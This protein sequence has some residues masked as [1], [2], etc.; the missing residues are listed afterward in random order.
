MAILTNGAAP[1]PTP[2]KPLRVTRERLWFLYCVAELAA[3]EIQDVTG[4]GVQ[5]TLNAIARWELSHYARAYANLQV[6]PALQRMAW[7]ELG[8]ADDRHAQKARKTVDAVVAFVRA[9]RDEAKMWSE[10][11]RITRLIAPRDWEKVQL[12]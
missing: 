7:R 12:Q 2:P 10:I 6:A 5:R 1:E 9:H 8:C 3:A 11:D 4:W